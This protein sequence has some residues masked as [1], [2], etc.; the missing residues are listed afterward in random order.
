[1]NPVI[2][3]ILIILLI[4]AIFMIF[5]TTTI[6][7]CVLLVK[8]SKKKWTRS[9]SMPEDEECVRMYRI[10]EEWMEENRPCLEDVDIHNDGLHLFGQYF[11]FGNK[12]AVIIVP[13]RM[14]SCIYSDYF[15][16]TYKKIGYNVLTIDSRAHGLSEGKVNC[17]G[18][19]EYRDV[20]AWARFLHEK[21]GVETIVLHGICIGASTCMFAITDADCPDYI[22]AISV[23]GMYVNFYESCYNHMKA[24]KRPIFPFFYLL[25]VYVRIFSHAN[26]ITDGPIYRIPKL[27]RPILFLHSKLDKYSLPDKAKLLYDTCTAEKEFVWFEKGGHSRVRINNVEQ[28]DKAVSDFIGKYVS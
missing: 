25:M 5:L 22:K 16:D 2:K 23:D 4:Q 13:G 20:L 19:R 15:G 8:T 27:N 24:D 1:M 6:I 28:Y 9:C 12:K 11:D 21:K 17:L 7:Y 26:V 3:W 18:Y 10:G 14:E